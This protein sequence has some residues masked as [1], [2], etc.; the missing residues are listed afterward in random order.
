MMIRHQFV[1]IDTKKTRRFA[2]SLRAL[3]AC[4]S[5]AQPLFA[6]A[7]APNPLPDRTASTHNVPTFAELES[8]GTV[9]RQIRIDPQ[10][11]FDL[12]DSEENNW[13]FRLANKLHIQTRPQVIEQILL[14]KRG[15]RVSQQKV[16]ET[17]RLL[18][19]NRL[20]Y[21]VNI[22]PVAYADG[23]V[24]IDVVTRDTWTIDIAANVSR[25][26]GNNKTSIGLREYNLLGT[27]LGIGFSRSSDV[28]RKGTEF[29]IFY[30]QAFDGWTSLSY[31][32]GRFDDGRRKSASIDRPFYALDTRWA[33]GARWNDNDRIDSIYNSGNAVSQYRHRQNFAEIFGGWSP[34][35]MNGWTQRFLLGL[36]SRDDT[37]ALAPGKTAPAVLPVQ[38]DE[39]S[40]FFRHELL[41]DKFIKLKNRD[42]IG[43]P[44]FFRT[45]FTSQLQVT[46][47][48]ESLGSTR[49]AWLYSAFVG[50][51]F[52][53][54][55]SNDLLVS[56][57]A[58]RRL[59]TTGTPMTQVG[60]AVRYYVPQGK[61]ALF[62]AAL[63][64]DGIKGGGIADQLLIGG[65][66]GL[67]GYPSYYQAGEHR[68]LLT[69]EQ[70]VYTDWYPF[71]L[72][73]VGGAAFFDVGRAWGGLNQNISNPGWL[74][75]AGVGLRFALDRSAFA[76]VLHADI[77]VPLNRT[78][79]IKSVQFVVKTEVTF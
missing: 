73:R 17:E 9:I 34:G 63:S 65:N 10:N 42:Q 16:N 27:G 32:Q 18:R 49:S 8:A 26:G 19:N 64:G 37:Y 51:G 77:A 72:V 68:A 20:I 31:S 28:D 45:G 74:A 76:N 25:A 24:D 12:T 78:P 52:S 22:K 15:E 11:I 1:S 61:D 60:A 36:R 14:F 40:V 6:Q 43:R 50:N 53:F 79:G 4:L 41:E 30:P 39:H 58:E 66:N 70:R 62:Y 44:E 29:D 38:R 55:S 47:A 33:G 46:R 13:L 35:L 48:L 56:G 5:I 7:P 54:A 59:A 67:R 2:R 23:M 71:R 69:L 21:D 75:D 3:T 57:K